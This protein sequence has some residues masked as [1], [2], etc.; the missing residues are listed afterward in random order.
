[1]ITR[2]LIA[3]AALSLALS[4]CAT[5]EYRDREVIREV[6]VPFHVPC[7]KPEEVPERPA[8]VATEHPI[9]PADAGERERILAAKVIQWDGYGEVADAIMRSCSKSAPKPE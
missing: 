8:R 4:G 7:P 9:R 3:A 1:M 5:V 2:R 6:P